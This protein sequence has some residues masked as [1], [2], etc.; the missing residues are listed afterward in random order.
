MNQC[1]NSVEYFGY[2]EHKN[3]IYLIIELCECSLDQVIKNKKLML[4]K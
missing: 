1:K 3:Y 2:F 4:K